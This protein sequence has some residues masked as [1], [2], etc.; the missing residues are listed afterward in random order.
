[1]NSLT[2]SLFL[3]AMLAPVVIVAQPDG[4]SRPGRQGAAGGLTQMAE[5]LKAFDKNG[6]LRIDADELP[7][8]Q[9]AFAAMKKLDK[10]SN[11]EIETGELETTRSEVAG[12]MRSRAAEAM[13]RVD[14]N[15]NRK[16]DA[17]EIPA[18]EQ[19][20]AKAPPEMMK[21][22]DQNGDGKLDE[23][24]VSRLNE[25]ISGFGGSGAGRRPG[26]RSSSTPGFRRPPE[27]SPEA[28]KPNAGETIKPADKP[29]DAPKTTP[30][31]ETRPFKSEAP[32]NKFGS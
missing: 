10:N 23:S 7:A 15:G 21:R 9:Q 28:A 26:T 6:N 13:K 5:A 29:A 16:I 4:K 24:E 30:T 19:M 2:C 25:R 1:M 31:P 11:G 14:K 17:D 3:L 22:L 32:P 27:K 12:Q 18:L 20:L 8:V